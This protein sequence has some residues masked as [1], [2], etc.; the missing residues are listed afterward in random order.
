MQGYFT[1]RDLS[2]Y[3]GSYITEDDLDYKDR[4]VKYFSSIDDL[5]TLEWLRDPNTGSG[6]CPWNE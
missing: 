3:I 2:D 6:V 5:K 1:I 4:Y